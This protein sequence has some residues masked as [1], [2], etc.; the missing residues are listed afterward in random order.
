VELEPIRIVPFAEAPSVR[1]QGSGSR[2]R[3]T[4]EGYAAVFG[5]KSEVLREQGVNRGLPFREIV[6]GP[7]AVRETLAKDDIRFVLNH[8]L[9][10]LMGRTSTGT[11]ELS[12]DTRGIHTRSE[13]PDTSYARDYAELV[14]RGDAGEM[15]FRFYGER[16]S[17]GSDAGETLR[18]LHSFRIR[19]VS[20]LT[21]PPAYPGTSATVAEAARML[22]LAEE[23]RAGRVL[24]QQ[25][26]AELEQAVTALQAIIARAESS[27]EPPA[28]EDGGRSAIAIARLRHEL[29]GRFSA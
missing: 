14:Q 21:V 26:L 10:Q 28:G 29:R 23:M 2:Q 1:A 19:E 9:T 22:K 16:D 4:F 3:F 11:L 25:T 13:L 15:S 18:T 17:F 8:E 24:S 6:A 7:E 27:A 5:Q 12:A 20:G